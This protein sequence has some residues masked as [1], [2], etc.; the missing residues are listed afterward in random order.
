MPETPGRTS[1]GESA[2]RATARRHLLDFAERSWLKDGGF[3]WLRG[4]GTVDPEHPPELWIN[5]RMTYVFSLAT[6]I[7]DDR[8]EVAAHG[9]QALATLFHDDDHGGWFAEVG[10][11]G[12]GCYEH[13]FVLLA[14]CTAKAAGIAG[15]QSLLDEALFVHGNRFWNE[16]SGLCVEEWS[17]HWRALDPYRGANSNMHT[18]EA[19]LFAA[20]VTGARVWRTRALSICDRLINRVARSNGWRLPEHF[21]TDWT[22]MLNYNEDRPDDPFRP[23]GATPGHGLEWSRLLVQLSASQPEP[24]PW[25]LEAATELFDRA[26]ADTVRD[27]APGICYTTDW[28]GRP[29]V[30]ERFHWVM[31]EA[32]LAAD[33]LARATGNFRFEALASRWWQEV[34]TYFVDNKSGSWHH[35]LSPTMGPSSRT[36]SGQPDAFHI[37]NALTLPDLPLAPTAA[38]T[39]AR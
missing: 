21:D 2:W 5:A 36:W 39:A 38:L 13:S 19:Y 23:Y 29:V 18:V 17:P 12:K 28:T 9:V 22:P 8:S 1:C 25:L 16:A 15:A 3:G 10:G 14:A 30:A 31:A 24:E 11:S 35:E 20:D 27:D 26:V 7:G 4:D 32:I 34:D 6:L 33:A 37:M